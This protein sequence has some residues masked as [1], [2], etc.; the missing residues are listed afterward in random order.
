M[1]RFEVQNRWVRTATYIVE[2]AD[3][4][5]AG[6]RWRDGEV[7]AQEDEMLVGQV[8]TRLPVD[9]KGKAHE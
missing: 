9:G 7:I 2:A 1:A 5:E 4:G 6:S 3:A 8:I